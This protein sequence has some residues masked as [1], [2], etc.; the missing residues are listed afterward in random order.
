MV[1]FT[2]R[3]N[4]ISDIYPNK[5]TREDKRELKVEGIITLVIGFI[6]L[7]IGLYAS[8]SLTIDPFMALYVRINLFPWF[9]IVDL[10]LIIVSLIVL[11]KTR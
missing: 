5:I 4:I 7:S 6:M 3:G 10:F 2:A 1:L 8:Y 9:I 11:I